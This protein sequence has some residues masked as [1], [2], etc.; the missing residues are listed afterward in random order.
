MSL[1][2]KTK[3]VEL[4]KMVSEFRVLTIPQITA[5]CFSREKV[6]QRRIKQLESEGLIENRLKR[7]GKSKGRPQNI[8][9]LGEHGFDLLKEKNVLSLGHEFKQIDINSILCLDH[10]LMLNWFRIHLAQIEKVIHHLKIHFISSNSPFSLKKDN[11][12]PFIYDKIPQHNSQKKFNRFIP[13]GVFSITDTKAK[14]SILFFLEVEL[15]NEALAS[16]CKK[17]NDIRQKILNYQTYFKLKMY[18][19]FDEVWNYRFN[20]FRLLFFCNSLERMNSVCDLTLDMPPSDFIWV[21]DLSKMFQNG[22]SAQIWTR[23]GNQNKKPESI[24]TDRLSCAS[25]VLPIPF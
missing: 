5:L 4:L 7:L 10:Q 3:D 20:G 12:L 9:S 24:L 11:K 22:L 13:D 8:Y 17:K 16:P 19:K 25:P 1:R 23:G 2:L 21:T 18:K 15:G 6:A 14:R